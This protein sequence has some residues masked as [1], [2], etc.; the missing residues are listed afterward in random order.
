M[1]SYEKVVK[2]ACKP[3]S[4]P[5][6]P[7]VF[8]ILYLHH[9]PPNH[10]FKYI[11]NIIAATW[12]EDGAVHDVCKALAPRF[13]EPNSIVC[14]PYFWP[15]KCPPSQH[16]AQIV[17]KA[18]LVLHTMIRN[19]ATDNIL[20]HLSQSDVLKLRNVYSGNWEG[21]ILCCPGALASV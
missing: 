11:D 16:S 5:P 3:K 9:P 20:T 4:A 17:F 21:Q 14:L 18:L 12:S 8:H 1:S 7:K 15:T 19:G 10:L 13:R 6:K 2:L